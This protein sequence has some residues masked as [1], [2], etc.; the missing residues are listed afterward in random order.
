MLPSMQR[1]AC[2]RQHVVCLRSEDDRGPRCGLVSADLLGAE[3][4]DE[5][6][7]EPLADLRVILQ[8]SMF[9]NDIGTWTSGFAGLPLLM[10]T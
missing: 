10:S 4:Y 3:Q 8:E 6:M 7:N 5:L 9:L 1:H 2:T